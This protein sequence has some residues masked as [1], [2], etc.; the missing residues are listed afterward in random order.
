MAIVR[1]CRDGRQLDACQCGVPVRSGDGSTSA[2]GGAGMARW[3]TTIPFFHLILHYAS[4]GSAQALLTF[5]VAAHRRRRGVA[6][7]RCAG[8]GVGRLPLRRFGGARRP[9][10]AHLE[11]SAGGANPCGARPDA[12]RQLAKS[13]GN[14]KCSGSAR[15]E[16]AH[17]PCERGLRGSRAEAGPPGA[18]PGCA[19]A[20]KEATP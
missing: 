4:I 2:R 3:T 15:A 7:L 8:P 13:L 12:R 6:A 18:C 17:P 19:G 20:E 5:S 11:K 16:T 1:K 9:L 10:P 14:D